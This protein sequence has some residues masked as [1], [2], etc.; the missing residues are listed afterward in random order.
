[1]ALLKVIC[2]ALIFIIRIKS[3]FN[4]YDLPHAPVIFSINF[5]IFNCFEIL[6]EPK[7]SDK[8]SRFT[9]G[10]GGGC[11][12]VSQRKYTGG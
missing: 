7:I 12:Y 9:E 4:T 11:P 2:W 1:M 5:G 6:T 3:T 10:E 8:L